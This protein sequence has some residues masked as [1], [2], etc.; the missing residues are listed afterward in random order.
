MPIL[1]T[2][3]TYDYKNVF[4][5]CLANCNQNHEADFGKIFKSQWLIGCALWDY[6]KIKNLRFDTRLFGQSLGEDVIF[7]LKASKTGPLLVNVGTCLEH[8]E[9]AKERPN[10]FNFYRMWVRNRFYIAEELSN[11]RY[12]LAFHWC[13]FGKSIALFILIIKNPLKNFISLAGMVYGYFDLIRESNA[14]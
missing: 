2:I 4:V 10:N 1:D 7:S 11:T 5:F 14:Y 12:K 9:S 8:T 13:N 3:L 6:Q